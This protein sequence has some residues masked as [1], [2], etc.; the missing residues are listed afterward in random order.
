M[1]GA[2]V[3]KRTVSRVMAACR[4]NVSFDQMAAPF[5]EILGSSGI[6][7]ASIYV[8]HLFQQFHLLNHNPYVS[9]GHSL[10]DVT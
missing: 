7:S 8:S 10:I 5:L 2:Y 1:I 4:S 9:V 6:P 3:W